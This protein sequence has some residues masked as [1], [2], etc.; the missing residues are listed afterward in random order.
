ARLKTAEASLSSEKKEESDYHIKSKIIIL[1]TDGQHNAGERSPREAA[2]LAAEWGIK[3][4]TIGVCENESMMNLDT[5][6]G[7]FR[8]PGAPGLD[9]ET[10]KAIAEETGGVYRRA[11]DAESLMAIYK[12]IDQLERSEIEAQ[13]YYDYRELYA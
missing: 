9:E 2:A 11:T 3:I 5:L 12:E 7:V 4:Y 1:L 8:T 13:R 6:F 10:L